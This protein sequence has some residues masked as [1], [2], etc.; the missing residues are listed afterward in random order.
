MTEDN[1]KEAREYVQ[2][3]LDDLING[4]CPYCQNKIEQRENIGRSVFA[5]P[6]GHRLYQRTLTE[7]EEQ[8]WH[9]KCCKMEND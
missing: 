8:E 3:F 1:R 9:E 6:C 4:I 5:R 2:R 7:K